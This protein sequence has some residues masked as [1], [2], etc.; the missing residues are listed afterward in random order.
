VFWCATKSFSFLPFSPQINQKKKE[1]WSTGKIEKRNSS[2]YTRSNALIKKKSLEQVRSRALEFNSV[3]IK[4]P[5]VHRLSLNRFP[6][7]RL[8][9]LSSDY[10]IISFFKKHT[11]SLSLTPNEVTSLMFRMKIPTHE[12]ERFGKGGPVPRR[13][14][15]LASWLEIIIIYATKTSAENLTWV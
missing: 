5:L 2:L 6:F 8:H 3:W 12:S 13:C 15:V 1:R 11:I 10:I 4:T 9:F 14:N 7:K